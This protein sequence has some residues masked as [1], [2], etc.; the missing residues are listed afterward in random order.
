MVVQ[1]LDQS[2][3]RFVELQSNVERMIVATLVDLVPLE[4][5]PDEH[6]QNQFVLA[7]HHVGERKCGARARAFAAGT[8]DDH[9][10]VVVDECHDLVAAFFQGPR[11]KGGVVPRP[12]TARRRSSNQDPFFH[13]YLRQ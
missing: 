9:D 5:R 3:P 10:G 12:E 2:D 6:R 7:S 11:R 13:G 4:R 8:D 1:D